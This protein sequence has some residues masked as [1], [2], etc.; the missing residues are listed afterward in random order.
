[1]Q[2]K[3]KR[4]QW[5]EVIVSEE[6]NH[7]MKIEMHCEFIVFTKDDTIWDLR[8][9][10]IEASGFLTT[11]SGMESE[12]VTCNAVTGLAMYQLLSIDSIPHLVMYSSI[13]QSYLATLLIFRWINRHHYFVFYFSE[14]VVQILVTTN[15]HRKGS[16]LWLR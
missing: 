13:D 3:D 16:K 7:V 14:T 6:A 15:T 10:R 11:H 8:V 2:A 9:S 4:S 5:A 1:M 12:T